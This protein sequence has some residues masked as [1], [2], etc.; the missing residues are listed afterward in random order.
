MV[1]DVFEVAW[2]G[3]SPC[4]GVRSVGSEFVGCRAVGLTR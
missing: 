2:A 4:Y 3:V 1:Y